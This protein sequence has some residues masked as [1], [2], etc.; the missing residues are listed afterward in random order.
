MFTPH[1]VMAER[2]AVSATALVMPPGSRSAVARIL[3]AFAPLALAT[4]ISIADDEMDRAKGL[5]R[6]RDDLL[7]PDPEGFLAFVERYRS[8]AVA[9]VTPAPDVHDQQSYLALLRSPARLVAGAA[10]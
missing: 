10:Q 1:G 4:A 6:L 9:Y 8:M 3:D 7:M 2:A 5:E